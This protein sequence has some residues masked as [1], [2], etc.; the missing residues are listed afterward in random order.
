VEQIPQQS[1]PLAITVQVSSLYETKSS[2]QNT[3]QVP[4]TITVHVQ[5]SLYQPKSSDLCQSQSIL[6]N[7][8][9]HSP[10]YSSLDKTKS[11]YASRS[12]SIKVQSRYL[13]SIKVRS[14]YLHSI[15]VRPQIPYSIKVHSQ[16]SI[17]QSPE[18][19][20]NQSPP[21]INTVQVPYSIKVHSFKHSLPY[22]SLG[23]T[24]TWSRYLYSITVHPQ[25]T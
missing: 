22:H 14:R 6:Q 16:V 10:P 24:K 18:S 12:L 23:M 2:P 20:Y 1:P 17:N 5:S 25:L 9:R 15:K 13:H 21:L 4:V 11:R 19:R 3:V 8:V 7:I